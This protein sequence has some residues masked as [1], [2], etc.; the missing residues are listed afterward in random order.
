[1]THNYYTIIAKGDVICAYNRGF[2][3]LINPRKRY[4]NVSLKSYY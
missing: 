2:N 4:L 1:M 3:V